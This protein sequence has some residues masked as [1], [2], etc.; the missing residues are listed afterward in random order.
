[1]TQTAQYATATVSR[2]SPAASGTTLDCGKYYLV[3]P[4]DYCQLVAVNASISLDLFEAINSSI[5]SACDN[6]LSGFYYCV[7]PTENWNGTSTV[8]S[9]PTAVPSGTTTDCYQSYVVQSG[10]YCALIESEFDITFTQLQL[11]N[12]S[13]LDDCSNLELGEAYCVSGSS[14]TA[15]RSAGPAIQVSASVTL[16]AST[17][18]AGRDVARAIETSGVSCGG[19]VA[20]GWPGFNSPRLMKAMGVRGPS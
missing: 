12:P 17:L 5:D 10:D 13:L 6:L 15:K 14:S 9:A 20:V 7:M 3:Q 4:G 8:V 1:V 19:G 2:P 18:K 11:W 16:G